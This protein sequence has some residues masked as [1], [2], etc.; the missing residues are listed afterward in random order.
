MSLYQHFKSNGPSGFGYGSTAEQVTEGLSLDGKT[1]LV[2]GCNSGLGQEAL[3]VLVL[4]GARVIGTART[5]EKAKGACDAVKGR[6][7]PVACELSDP[8]SVR[9]CVESVKATGHRLDA[10]ICNAGIMALPKL[11]QA[12]GIELQFLTNHVGHFILVTGLLDRLAADGRVVMLSSG[13]HKMA[14][15]GGIKF[16]NLSGEKGYTPWGNYGQSKIANLLFAKELAR[17]FAGTKRT[18][19]AVHPGVIQTNLGRHMNPV[20]GMAFGLT[21][22]LVLKSVPQGAATEV[23][24]AVHPAVA[25]SSGLYFA[26]CNVAKPRADAEDP[27]LAAKLWEVTEKIVAGL[28]TG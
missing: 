14:P 17:R 2:T 13:A 23:Y 8:A 27:A 3:R 20:A 9:A 19:N 28:P 1:I 12:H 26:D 4:R 10:I 18:A 11:E 21:G 22:P 6:T 15:K 24:V 5:L 7:V 16:D 25:N